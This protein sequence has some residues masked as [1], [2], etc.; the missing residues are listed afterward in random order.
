MD[1]S[2]VSNISNNIVPIESIIIRPILFNVSFSFDIKAK[3][4]KKN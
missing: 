3:T 4:K 2:P 1:C